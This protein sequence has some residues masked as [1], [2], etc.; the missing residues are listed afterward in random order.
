[1]KVSL[2]WL[3]ELVSVDASADEIAQRL[4]L[5]GIEVEGRTEV[6]QDLA[7]VVVCEIRDVRRH[8]KSDHLTLV[9]VF[10]GGKVTQVVCGAPQVPPPGTRVSWARPGALLPGGLHIAAKEVRGVSS[11]GM[12]LAEDELGL[13]ADHSGLL[14]VEEEAAPGDDVAALLGG[15]DTVLELNITPNR[16]DCLGHW[17]V[18]REVSALFPEA[19]LRLPDLSL[20]HLVDEPVGRAKVLIDDPCGCP[21]YLARIVSH[22]RIGRSA[23]R[24]RRR[25]Q[26]L[27]VRAINDIV[28]ATNLIMLEQ[29]Q[30]LHAFD[31]EQLAGA[32]IVVR[33][34]RPGETMVTLDG[35][36]RRL[37]ENDLLICDAERPVAIAGV[38]GGEGSGISPTTRHLLLESAYFDPA[39]VRRTA[40]R[41]GLHT[42]AS[43]RFERG[44]DPNL[45]LERA[46]LRCARH[47]ALATGGQV[48]RQPIDVY[49]RTLPPTVV[50]LR[51]ARTAHVLGV[52]VSRDEQIERLRRLELDPTVVTSTDGEQIRCAVPTFRPDLTR[53]IDLIEE[54]ARL[55]GYDS[56]PATL[57]ETSRA[58]RA[59]APDLADRVR[60]ALVSLGLHEAITYGFTAP[61]LIA[62][63][64][65][66][67]SDRR[68]QPIRLANP[69]GEEVSAMRTTLL[70]GLLGVLA[71][72]LARGVKD[73]RLFEVGSVFLPANAPLPDEELE[74]CFL[75]AGRRDGWL[76]PGDEIDYFD[77]KGL[78]DSLLAHLRVAGIEFRP[79]Q[80]G[81]A[82]W[83]HPGVGAVVTVGGTYVGALG[84]VHP[85]VRR[86][87]GLTTNVVAAC[88]RLEA[89]P[90]GAAPVIG[91]LPRFPSSTRDISFFVDEDVP[92]ATLER[93]IASSSPLIE[94]VRVC[95]DYR[96]PGRV[97]TGKKGMLWSLSYRATDRTLTDE[98]IG[99]EHER[100]LKALQERF[101]I[102]Q[103]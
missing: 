95:E 5:A 80:E 30:P 50:T 74:A 79:P 41:L 72:N 75:L 47:L 31:L 49:P 39:S 4:T 65:W 88:L 89:L 3:R 11:P 60:N 68:S 12:L 102:Q 27:G 93:T 19:V 56:V 59:A 70:T 14:V 15:A 10:D 87:L 61:D 63:L 103:R 73:V 6:G 86:R 96:E 24:L 76:K 35:V 77:V 2:Q 69:L 82:P 22:I 90:A 62:K 91:E 85:E 84:E 26:V 71:E 38:M 51:P 13:S 36:E 48:G 97:P 37:L 46:S 81:E 34:A 1:M 100:V 101:A 25:L 78:V 53:E 99:G 57:P 33:R 7:G 67:S 45:G 52:A 94:S 16:P 28:D 42:E 21:R 66:A 64:G 54:I 44:A 29:G 18:A 32:T 8:P 23:L 9:D 40:R 92:A 58:P 17:G 98:E 55:R 83:L 43:H 20:P